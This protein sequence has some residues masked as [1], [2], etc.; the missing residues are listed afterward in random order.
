MLKDEGNSKLDPIHKADEQV[1][2]SLPAQRFD[3]DTG[4][5][6]FIHLQFPLCCRCW[7][8]FELAIFIGMTKAWR[9]HAWTWLN[10]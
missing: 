10:K 1:D 6:V 2:A 9:Y 7:R 4:S 8:L 3:G 5:G